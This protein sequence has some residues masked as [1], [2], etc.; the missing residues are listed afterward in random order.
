MSRH[1]KC[2]ELR[3][4]STFEATRIAPECLA[5]AYERLVPIPRRSLR[6]ARC[7]PL[8]VEVVDASR[9]MPRSADCG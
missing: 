9:P 3:I 1:P 2:P 5:N 4:H 8:L 6:S 7:E